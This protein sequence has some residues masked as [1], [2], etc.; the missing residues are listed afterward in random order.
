M[1]RNPRKP[2]GP[3]G[4]AVDGGSREARRIA[5]ALL[6]VLAGERTCVQAAESLGISLSRYYAL[7]VHAL[8]GFVTALEPRTPGRNP[9]P[10]RAL[11]QLEEQRAKLERD[12]ARL[13][14]LVRSAGRAVGLS[15]PKA[16]ATAATTT[17]KTGKQRR[18][19]K[20]IARALRAAQRLQSSG[21]A[22][23]PSS[24]SAPPAPT[25]A[26]PSPA[27]QEPGKD[28]A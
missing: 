22:P 4:P 13:T 27:G 17:T 10:E 24:A 25:R 14:A 18:P 7:E 20:P 15:A 21:A 3:Q 11:A 5:A 1:P 19:K 12:N 6:E 9:S 26:T 16:P 8:E 23:A 2:R 28:S